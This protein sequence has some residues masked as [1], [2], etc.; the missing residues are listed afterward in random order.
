MERDLDNINQGTVAIDFN[1]HAHVE[2]DVS[3]GILW[4]EPQYFNS[5]AHVERD[6]VKNAV[7]VK[8][9]NFNS[10]AHVERD[11]TCTEMP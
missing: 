6:A 10:H 2:R 5:H 8:Y 4:Q 9:T 3:A 1:S 11:R 7:A